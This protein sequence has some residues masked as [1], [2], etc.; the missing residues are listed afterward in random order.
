MKHIGFGIAIGIA[1]TIWTLA[2]F[3][4][5]TWN[6]TDQMAVLTLG[7]SRQLH[8]IVALCVRRWRLRVRRTGESAS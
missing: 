3:A 2:G 6:D 5:R 1:V 8:R 4:A 7:A